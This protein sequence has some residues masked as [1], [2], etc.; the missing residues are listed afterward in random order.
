MLLRS[1]LSFAFLFLLRESNFSQAALKIFSVS[2]VFCFFTVM[3]LDFPVPPK[4]KN[5]C[6]S[7]IL[8]N[9]QSLAF[10]YFASLQSLSF[11]NSN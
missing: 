6:N 7:S 8:E 9:Y 3:C 1:I 5:S 10:L 4:S 2:L 11:S